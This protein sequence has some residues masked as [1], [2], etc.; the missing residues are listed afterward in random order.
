MQRLVQQMQVQQA[1]MPQGGGQGVF[2][3]GLNKGKDRGCSKDCQV[4]NDLVSVHANLAT[5]R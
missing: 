2:A 3:A 5:G 1:Q 4:S